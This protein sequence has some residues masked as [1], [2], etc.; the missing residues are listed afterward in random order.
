[1][2][3]SDEQ[4]QNLVEAMGAKFGKEEAKKMLRRNSST[5]SGGAPQRGF[6]WGRST[7]AGGNDMEGGKRESPPKERKQVWKYTVRPHATIFQST[8]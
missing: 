4:V 6:R 2:H 7:L 1:M 5:S 8:V 3:F